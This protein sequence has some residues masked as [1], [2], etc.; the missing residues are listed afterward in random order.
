M[1]F[2]VVRKVSMDAN[3]KRSLTLPK[4]WCEY[5]ADRLET[6]TVV[7]QNILIVAPEGLEERALK[8]IK[9]DRDD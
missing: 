5:F 2:K 7:G 1:A 3:G 9:E 8:L 4:A 6:V